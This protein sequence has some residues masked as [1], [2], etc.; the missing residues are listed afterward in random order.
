M[1]EKESTFKIRLYPE[2][3]LTHHV[4]LVVKPESLPLPRT[5]SHDAAFA[6]VAFADVAFADVAFADVASI[7]FIASYAIST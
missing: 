6:D 3:T 2:K 7:D 5:A 4:D 1:I